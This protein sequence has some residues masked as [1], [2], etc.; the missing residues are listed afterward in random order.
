MKKELLIIALGALMGIQGCNVG[1]APEPMDANQVNNAV[2]NAKPEDQIAFWNSSPLPP[3][4][5]KAKI[6][7]IRK[8]YNLPDNS[9]AQGG[10]PPGVTGH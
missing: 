8:K 4:E 2:N 10:P 5:K 1:N 9:G 7:A 6:D 3:A